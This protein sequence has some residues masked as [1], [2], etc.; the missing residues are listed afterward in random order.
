[1]TPVSIDSNKSDILSDHEIVKQMQ[2][3]NVLSDMD[4]SSEHNVATHQSH[5]V[6]TKFDDTIEISD[7][8]AKGI[9]DVF[10]IIQKHTTVDV[11][12][13]LED[14][15]HYSPTISSLKA[16]P[17]CANKDNDTFIYV[18]D[19]NVVTI[20]IDIDKLQKR[21]GYDVYEALNAFSE[22]TTFNDEYC[23]KYH[24]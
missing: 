24:I 6:N 13:V 7:V 16:T 10:D 8:Q 22:K 3:S 18:K 12:H 21:Y 19:G 4:N 20:Y 14:I 1:M 17:V 9:V 11:S 23:F 5:K 2:D 15:K